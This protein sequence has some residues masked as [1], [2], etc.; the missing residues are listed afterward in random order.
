MTFDVDR[1]PSGHFLMLLRLEQRN[2]YT[3][4]WGRGKWP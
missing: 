3:Q 2:W 4:L 1:M